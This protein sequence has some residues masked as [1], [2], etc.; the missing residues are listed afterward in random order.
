MNARMG[1]THF[2]TKT[3]LVLAAPG[4]LVFGYILYAM[5]FCHPGSSDVQMLR[6]VV[7]IAP[8]T[9]KPAAWLKSSSSQILR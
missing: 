7:Q 3:L 4:P 1:A 2:L 8:R 9:S 5:N 6:R